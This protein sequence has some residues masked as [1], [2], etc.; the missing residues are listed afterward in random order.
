M[1]LF[2]ALLFAITVVVGGAVLVSAQDRPS[3]QAEDDRQENT[4]PVE[5]DYEALIKEVFAPVTDQLKLTKEQ[6]FRIVAIITSSEVTSD[7]LLQKVDEVGRRL[8]D[9]TL[10]DSPDD[11]LI[12]ELSEQEALLLSQ[13]IA[14]KSRAK[15]SI[16]QLLTPAQRTLVSHQFR[17]KPQLEGTL[18]A[19]GIY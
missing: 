14:M 2:H 10:V 15:A 9:A 6:E 1:K 19:I 18:G 8:A 7:P 11:T 3:S 17:G 4:P 13:V 12:N 5:R 16:F